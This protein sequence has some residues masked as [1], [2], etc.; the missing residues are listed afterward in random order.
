MA[1]GGLV[2]RFDA[3]QEKPQRC[4]AIAFDYD[5]WSYA[6]NGQAKTTMP[7]GTRKITIEIERE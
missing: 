4:Y 1:N 7:K 5:E 2:V 6:I 3:E